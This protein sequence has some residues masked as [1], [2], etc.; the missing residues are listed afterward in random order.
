MKSMST[1]GFAQPDVSP[2]SYNYRFVTISGLYR[3][4]KVNTYLAFFCTVRL[5]KPLQPSH[6]LT[7]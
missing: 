6:V 7:P 1:G 3:T 5:K 4:N 2:C